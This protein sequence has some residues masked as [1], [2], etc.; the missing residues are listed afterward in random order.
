MVNAEHSSHLFLRES[1]SSVYL[2]DGLHVV[3]SEFRGPYT[4]SPRLLDALSFEPASTTDDSS[5]S[6]FAMP[7]KVSDLVDRHSFTPKLSYGLD[8][9]I[10]DHWPA[11]KAQFVCMA[12]DLLLCAPPEIGG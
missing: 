1:A 12:N 6:R 5:D 3:S 11:R 9:L 7:E 10:R 8:L 4:T 2:S